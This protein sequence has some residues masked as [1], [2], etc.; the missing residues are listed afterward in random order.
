[1]WAY[2]ITVG[3]NTNL[4]LGCT[5]GNN[6]F[7]STTQVINAAR[8]GVIAPTS[9]A[10]NFA[11]VSNITG[12]DEVWFNSG[13]GRY[14]L[15]ASKSYTTTPV[16]TPVLEPNKPSIDFGLDMKVSAQPG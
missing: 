11:D 7:D 16:C 5:P 9:A 12:C 1:M 4:M 3:P 6:P 8:Q 2:G 14:Y 13:D 15:G 10:S